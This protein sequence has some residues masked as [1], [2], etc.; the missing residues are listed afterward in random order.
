MLVS[1]ANAT[2]TAMAEGAIGKPIV[3]VEYLE[4]APWNQPW[5]AERRLGGVG[6][7]LLHQ[8]VALSDEEE[9]SGRVGLHALPNS[10]SFYLSHRMS[11]FGPDSRHKERL[12]YFEYTAEV[13]DEMLS[14]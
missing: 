11:D 5:H 3:Y 6:T 14:S 12:R 8:A 2:Y 7:S 9:F 4:S 10:E 13:L 1:I